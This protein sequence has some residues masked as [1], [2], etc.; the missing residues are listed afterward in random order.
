M[1]LRTSAAACALASTLAAIHQAAAQQVPDSIAVQNVPAVSRELVDGLNR[2]QNIR[3]AVFQDWSP[4]GRGLLILT[5]FAETNQVHRVA[6]PL[7]DREQVTFLRER[8]GETRARPGMRQLLY[9]TDEGGAENF[10]LSL[11]DLGTGEGIRVTD[12]RSRNVSPRWSRSGRWL[13]C[14]RR[15]RASGSS[16]TGRRTTRR[17]RPSNTFRPTNRTS[18]W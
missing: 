4:D 18:I 2:Y 17:S 3:L 16:R 6:A 11:L 10:Q 7:A 14:S 15:C 9:S 8:V 13:A 5:R 1:R 12:G